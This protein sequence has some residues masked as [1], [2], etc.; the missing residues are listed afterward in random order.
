MCSVTAFFGF[1]YLLLCI[2]D[3]DLYFCFWLFAC[4]SGSLVVAVVV[5]VI[6]L[7]AE[8]NTSILLP[9]RYHKGYSLSVHKYT[10]I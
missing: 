9:L 3:P 5:V 4:M 6:A 10:Y 7:I 1:L 2:S 8:S